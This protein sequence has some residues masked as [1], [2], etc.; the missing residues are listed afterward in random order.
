MSG[1]DSERETSSKTEELSGALGMGGFK[2]KGFTFSG[3]DPP[4][5]LAN[6]DRISINVGGSIWFP[7]RDVLGIKIPELNF[8]KKQR[9]KK[10]TSL[11]GLIP[12]NLKMRNCVSRVYEIFDLMGRAAPLVCGFKMD[13]TELHLRELD[14]ENT[15]PDN[16][17]N[18]CISNI[19]MIEEIHAVRY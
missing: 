11:A 14:W 6:D 9:G 13:I 18:L 2:L 16:L 17:R 15:I 7:K 19:E 5:N 12:E 4:P 3:M 10:S 1:A 8:G